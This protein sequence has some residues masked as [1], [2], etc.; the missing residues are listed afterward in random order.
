MLNTTWLT[1]VI[2]WR[3]N[4]TFSLTGKTGWS[5]LVLRL[6]YEWLANA[7]D[8]KNSER[9]VS[10]LHP[11]ALLWSTK[12][13]YEPTREYHHAHAQFCNI[14][15]PYEPTRE[16]ETFWTSPRFASRSPPPPFSLPPFPPFN[17]APIGK[18]GDH[19]IS[20][21]Q[22]LQPNQASDRV[23]FLPE[24]YNSFNNSRVHEKRN[25]KCNQ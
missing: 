19:Y 5:F 7:S 9:S 11:Y 20:R 23:K 1:Y 16:Y 18:E 3:T 10:D 15:V 17:A 13:P 6:K 25:Q 4:I 12:V 21:T 8:R 2:S 22:C 14:K 24:C